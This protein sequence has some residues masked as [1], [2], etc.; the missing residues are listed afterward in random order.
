[1]TAVDKDSIPPL[2]QAIG[3]LAGQLAVDEPGYYR[4]ETPDGVSLP[5]FVR[6]RMGKLIQR[7][8]DLLGQVR[9]WTVYPKTDRLGRLSC[10]HLIGMGA[11]PNR[12]VEEFH[13]SGRVSLAQADGLIA[14]RIQPNRPSRQTEEGKPAVAV[15]TFQPFYINLHGYLSGDIG[16]EIW[17]FICQR[18]GARLEM[19]DGARVK[20]RRPKKG[21]K[22][23]RKKDS[24]SVAPA[25][26]PIPEVVGEV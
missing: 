12:P 19:I 7:K 17:R 26:N 14:V 9:P 15:K 6:G 23:G 24:P 5:M 11:Q 8:P 1:M 13:I 22:G 20:G 3:T 18:E 16:G 25:N 2:F 10:V 21:R 4:L